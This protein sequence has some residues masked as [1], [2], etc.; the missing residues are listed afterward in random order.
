MSGLLG[1]DKGAGGKF[2]ILPPG[3]TE[4]IPEGYV[5]L[6]SDTYGGYALLRSN[7][8]SHGDADVAKSIAYAKQIKV[9][10]LAQADNPPPT[11]FTDVQDVLFDSTIRFDSSFFEHLDRIVQ[12]EP[13]LDRD[14]AMIDQ[15]RSLGIAKGKPFK[16][17]DARTRYLLDAAALEAKA[18]LEAK[19]DAAGRRSSKGHSGEPLASRNSIEGDTIGLCTSPDAYPTDVRGMIYT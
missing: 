6:Q 16:P 19:Y 12:N 4:P 3:Y 2:L 14:R 18:W 17:D 9:Y 13:W 11:V 15:L 1:V 8:E 7:L 5:P 10:P